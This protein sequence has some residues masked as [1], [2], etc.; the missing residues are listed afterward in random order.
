MGAAVLRRRR[1][2]TACAS[3]FPD[4]EALRTGSRDRL[5]LRPDL[6]GHG[7]GESFV[8]TCLR[9]ASATLGAQS[10]TIVVAAFN[11]RAIIVYQ[12]AGFQ[13]AERFEH[14]TNGGFHA[15]IRIARSTI[16][17]PA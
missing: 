2:S 6:T 8:R 3:R 1:D 5:G 15:F 13:K 16:E 9:F 11:R 4:G 14:F 7:L 17:D 10:Y 12:L